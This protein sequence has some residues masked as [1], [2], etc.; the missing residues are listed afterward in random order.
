VRAIIWTKDSCSFCIKAK[1]LLTANKISFEERRIDKNWTKQQL[2]EMV[3]DARTV[4][5]IF[6]D[7]MYIGGYTDLVGFIKSL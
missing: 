4:P 2:L 5:Q 6:I 7:N 3:P 1:N